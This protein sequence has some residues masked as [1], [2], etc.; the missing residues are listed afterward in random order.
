[1]TQL[2][3]SHAAQHEVIEAQVA[4]LHRQ[5]QQH[6]PSIIW[7]R[8]RVLQQHAHKLRVGVQVG[9]MRLLQP[10]QRPARHGTFFEI[11][12][13]KFNLHATPRRSNLWYR[14]GVSAQVHLC[15]IPKIR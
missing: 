10:R 1:M 2:I 7:Q 11:H 9:S 12:A 15:T 5:S 14:S 6:L 13:Q 3:S 4:L 8:A